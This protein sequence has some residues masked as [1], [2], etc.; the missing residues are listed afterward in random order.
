[1]RLCHGCGATHYDGLRFCRC[2]GTA[3]FAATAPQP[4]A[5]EMPQP[6]PPSRP[7][8][9]PMAYALPPR[10]SVLIAALLALFL[11]P[12]GMLYST[13]LGTMVMLPASI[14]LAVLTKGASVL[15]TWPICV[16]WAAISA[17]TWNED[18]R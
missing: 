12:L 10:K 11:G 8:A 6:E 9:Q 18:R 15:I 13:V 5:W 17:Q 1:M 7:P 2:C 3:L 14:V 4:P 16:V